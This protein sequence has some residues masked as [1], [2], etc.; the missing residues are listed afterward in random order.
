MALFARVGQEENE[1]IK[2]EIER[3]VL[4]QQEVFKGRWRT[5]GKRRYRIYNMTEKK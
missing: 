3:K 5:G 2:A 1:E 4:N